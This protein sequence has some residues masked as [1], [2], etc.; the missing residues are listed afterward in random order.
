MLQIPGVVNMLVQS[1]DIYVSGRYIFGLWGRVS[2]VA[3]ASDCH[4]ENVGSFPGME[5]AVDSGKGKYQ[6]A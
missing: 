4:A 3:R 2:L 1:A 6:R 5:M